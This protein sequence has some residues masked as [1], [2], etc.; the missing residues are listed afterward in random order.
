[1][2][3]MTFICKKQHY[4]SISSSIFTAWNCSNLEMSQ[5][6]FADLVTFTG[7]ILNMENF[8]FFAMPCTLKRIILITSYL[9]LLLIF[10]VRHQK[11]NRLMFVVFTFSTITPP[12][13]VFSFDKCG[14]IYGKERRKIRGLFKSI[15]FP[16]SS[17][18][19]EI[20]CNFIYKILLIFW[21]VSFFYFLYICYIFFYFI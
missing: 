1:M 4:V 17:F 6:L 9:F 18:F 5:N 16:W 10:D 7:D 8:M 3:L 13:F 2:N 14:A 21:C 20:R 15:V 12:F 19:T 11:W